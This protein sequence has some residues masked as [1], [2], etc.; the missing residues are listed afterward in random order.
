MSDSRTFTFL[1][2]LGAVPFAAGAVLPLVE[3][4]SI[5]LIGDVTHALATYG[6]TILCFLT[7]IQWATQ[8]YR[9]ESTPFNLFIISNVVFLVVLAAY[10]AAPLN[11]ALGVQVFA[12]IAVLVIDIRLQGTGLLSSPYMRIRYIATSVACLSL[13]V[14]ILA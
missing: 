3:V 4:T 5:V 14:A 10:L 12:F 9:P 6:L 2:L 13:L 1:A 7:G 11:T 8:L